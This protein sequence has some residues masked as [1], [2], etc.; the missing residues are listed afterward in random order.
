MLQEEKHWYFFTPRER[1]YPKGVQPRR[2]T[3]YG[4]WKA[5]IRDKHIIYEN[6][7]VGYKMS[8][9]F[10]EGGPRDGRKTEWKMH[11]YRILKKS[12]L[13]T[14]NSNAADSMKVIPILNSYCTMFYSILFLC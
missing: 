4:Y 1:K 5:M 14:R 10:Y 7:I 12:L 8:L 11:E 2:A 6:K 9:N 13:P 3:S